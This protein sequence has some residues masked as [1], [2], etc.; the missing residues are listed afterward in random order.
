MR[1][2]LV[3]DKKITKKEYNQ[4]EKEDINFWQQYDFGRTQVAYVKSVQVHKRR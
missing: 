2:L 4:W 1:H 3:L